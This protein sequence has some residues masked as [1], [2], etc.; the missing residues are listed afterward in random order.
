MKFNVAAVLEDCIERGLRNALLNVDQVNFEYEN[1]TPIVDNFRD[2]I[3]NEIEDYFD[4][5]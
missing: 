2:R 1:L 5:E 3:M 4:F